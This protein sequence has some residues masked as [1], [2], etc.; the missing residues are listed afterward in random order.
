[1]QKLNIPNIPLERQYSSSYL[2]CPVCKMVD[3]NILLE[4]VLMKVLKF[5]MTFCQKQA[6]EDLEM[7]LRACWL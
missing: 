1:M 2:N 3:N 5:S 7:L 4:Q 6:L